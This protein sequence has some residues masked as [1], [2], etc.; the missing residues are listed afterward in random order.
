M[1][2]WELSAAGTQVIAVIIDQGHAINFYV[3]HSHAEIGLFVQDTFKDGAARP[4]FEIELSAVLWWRRA[5]VHRRIHM[6]FGAVDGVF[7]WISM[8]M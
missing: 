1:D 6:G 3:A 4:R 7:R 2:S 8:S 5:F